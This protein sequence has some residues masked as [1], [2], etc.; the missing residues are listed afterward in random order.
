MNVFWGDTM[1]KHELLVPAG[2]MECLRQAVYNGCDAVYLAC[3]KFGA[4]KFANNFS[5]EEILEAIRFCHLYGVKIYITMNTLVKNQEVDDFISQARFL[6]KNGVDALI[7]QDFGMI[8]LLR[9]M[10]PNLEIHASTQANISSYDVC[11]LYYDLGVKRVVFSRELTIDEIDSIDVPIEKEAF[12]HGA[13]CISYSG[14]CLMSSMLGGRSGNRGECAGTC[15]LPYSLLKNGKT[16]RSN[17]YL[18]STK[19]LNTS[20]KI[21]RLLSSSVYSFKIEG[22]MKSPLYVGFITKFYRS[23][24][25]GVDISLSDE[26]DKLKIIFNRKF[27]VGRMFG[28]KDEDFMNTSS[29]NHQGLEIGKVIDIT[30]DKIKIKLSPKVSLHQGDAIRFKESKKG[31][32]VNYLYDLN[33]N[34]VSSIN[35]ICYVENKVGLKEF[36]I[37]SKTQDFLLEKEF[38]SINNK[39]IPI[40]INVVAKIN[41]PLMIKIDDGEFYFEESDFCVYEAKN[42]PISK[43]SII[44]HLTKLG[45][46]PF[47]C[48][49]VSI[50]MDNN[51]FIPVSTINKIR[52]SLVSKL[53]FARENRKV[54]FVEKRV[55]FDKK[56][57][58]LSS[59]QIHCSVFT[60]EQLKMC[61]S[62]G[63]DRV[64]VSRKLYSKYCDDNRVYLNVERCSF[65]PSKLLMEKSL[66]SDYLHCNQDVVG[67]YP[68]NV[69]NIYTAYYLQKYGY[70]EICLSVELSEK[71]IIDFYNQY[72]DKFGY[73]LFEVFVY[74]RVENMI[75]KG[76]ILN[77]DRNQYSYELFDLKNRYFP[78]YYDGVFTHILNYKEIN[79]TSF[80]DKIKGSLRFDF[81]LESQDEIY[82]IL[83]NIINK[84]QL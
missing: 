20:S 69:F 45:N 59:F 23:L 29:P 24:I 43:D 54:D 33:G 50:Q 8:C 15:R 66:I 79:N 81:Y 63:V 74:G 78:V 6:H 32:V 47:Y 75:I 13:L 82:Q 14:C 49:N 44:E 56:N 11:Q 5:N 83:K 61:L 36:D 7:V 84:N 25:D 40:S 4:R 42:N 10:F 22:R 3:K 67:N 51:I 53:V 17:E 48:F 30:A 80:C 27:T 57:V 77:I 52:R 31:F 12:I 34:L 46:T 73:G 9:A 16:I 37:V 21:K 35:N 70:S 1:Q 76:N 2:N 18:L 39:K 28:E 64:Y 58:H 60:E 55:N 62:L 71:E 38:M 72:K 68:L 19:E 41:E 26:I 65:Y